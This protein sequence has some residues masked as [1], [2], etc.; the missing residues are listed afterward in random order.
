[1]SSPFATTAARATGGGAVGSVQSPGVWSTSPGAGAV[2]RQ[3]SAFH[4]R[5]SSSISDISYQEVEDTANEPFG[6]EAQVEEYCGMTPAAYVVDAGPRP[7]ATLPHEPVASPTGPVTTDGTGVS[8][9]ANG[10]EV[11]E[12]IESEEQLALKI[13]FSPTGGLLK[14]GSLASSAFNLASTAL[15]AGILGIP[16]SMAQSGMLVGLIFLIF[17]CIGAI[18][19]IWLL[20][21][22]VNMLDAPTYELLAQKAFGKK[23]RYLAAL[24]LMLTTFVSSILY[25]KVV[26]SIMTPVHAEIVKSTTFPDGDWGIRLVQFIFWLVVMLPLSLL[27]EINSLRYPSMIGVCSVV[28]LIMAVV[29]HISLNRSAQD[30]EDNA[31]VATVPSLEWVQSLNNIKFAFGAQSTAFPVYAELRPHILPLMTKATSIAMIGCTI[32]YC[33]AGCLGVLDFGRGV[34]DNLLDAFQ[35]PMRE[36]YLI[37]AYV[38]FCFTIVVSFPIMM[39]PCRDACIQWFLGYENPADCPDAK[40][41][42]VVIVLSTTSMAIGLFVPSLNLMFGILGGVFANLVSFVLPAAIALKTGW[43]RDE[44]GLLHVIG[45]WALLAAGA[46]LGPLGTIVSIYL[47]LT[48]P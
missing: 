11:H 39:L 44:V 27:K 48:K 19:S 43:T 5:N 22:L 16:W 4:S 14:K 12:P 46:L 17:C 40:R 28:F 10:E 13:P 2:S 29:I 37:L 47:E 26:G 32:I 8:V 30:V 23:G 15:G 41:R 20:M 1:M 33:V 38:S 25:V 18:Y 3:S 34:P 42:G 24:S 36:W 45:V 31:V 21:R 6:M 7:S 35:E 9:D